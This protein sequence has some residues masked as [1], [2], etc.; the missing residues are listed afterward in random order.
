LVIVSVNA[1]T[2]EASEIVEVRAPRVTAELLAAVN[3]RRLLLAELMAPLPAE[4][5]KLVPPKRRSDRNRE[6]V[7]A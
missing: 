4:P 5:A 7:E 2:S 6:H 3:E 1:F